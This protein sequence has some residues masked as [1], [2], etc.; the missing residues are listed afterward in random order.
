METS[1]LTVALISVASDGSEELGVAV[2]M[3][4]AVDDEGAVVA[5]GGGKR[6]GRKCY[7]EKPDGRRDFGGLATRFCLVLHCCLERFRGRSAR[8]YI[9]KFLI[10]IRARSKLLVVLLPDVFP[11]LLV[12]LRSPA[13]LVS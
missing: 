8:M 7:L 3:A 12:D 2:D 10:E 5:D 6:R 11:L 1:L 13:V 9:C 4:A